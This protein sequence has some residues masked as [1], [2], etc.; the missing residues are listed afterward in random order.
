VE[1]FFSHIFISLKII[2][3]I[4]SYHLVSYYFLAKNILMNDNIGF[5]TDDSICD[6]DLRQQYLADNYLRMP[7]VGDVDG[8]V[9]EEKNN[10]FF[11]TPITSFFVNNLFSSQMWH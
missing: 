3:V 2:V 5:F 6:C 8:D 7:R 4:P 11:F 10:L 9:N 1:Q